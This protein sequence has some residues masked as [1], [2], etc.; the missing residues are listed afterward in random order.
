MMG[1]PAGWVTDPKIGLSRAAQLKM[2][3]NGVCP[4]QAVVALRKLL[5]V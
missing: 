3:G 1:W 4:Q 2:I 5:E